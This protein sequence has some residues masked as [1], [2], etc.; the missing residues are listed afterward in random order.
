M[1][2]QYPGKL[3]AVSLY[4]GHSSTSITLDMYV[5]TQLSDDELFDLE[6]G[7]I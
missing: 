5:H 3:D 6:E 2:Q 7:A 1:V 4:L